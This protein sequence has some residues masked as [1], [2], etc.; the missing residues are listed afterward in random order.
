MDNPSRQQFNLSEL[1]AQL[2]S[3]MVSLQTLGLEDNSLSAL[4]GAI[5]ADAA[6]TLTALYLGN[7]NLIQVDGSLFSGMA[8]L[9]TLGLDGN[10]VSCNIALRFTALT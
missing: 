5:F 9:Q 4:D 7:N 8:S 10:N 6:A 3:G 2:F 1:D